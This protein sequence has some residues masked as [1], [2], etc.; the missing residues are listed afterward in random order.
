MS[1]LELNKMSVNHVST[2]ATYGSPVV[3]PTD[4]IFFLSIEVG[5]T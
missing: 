2:G 4:A 5:L 1:P 3:E